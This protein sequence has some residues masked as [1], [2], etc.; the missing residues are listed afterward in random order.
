MSSVTINANND[1]S[2]GTVTSQNATFLT[3][4]NAASGNSASAPDQVSPRCGLSGGT[5]FILR[6]FMKFS[7]SSIPTGSK[8]NSVT[9][10]FD[11]GS[12]NVND[13]FSL[14]VVPSTASN[15][16]V[17]SDFS[18]VSFSSY[19]E[20]A[21]AS[22]SVGTYSAGNDMALNAT[23]IAAVQSAIGSTFAISLIM[24]GDLNA[25]APSNENNCGI[26]GANGANPPRIVVNY[27]PPGGAALF[28]II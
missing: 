16:L 10:Q 13:G 12:K 6:G 23:G 25:T 27:S 2:A 14:E 20:L 17:T 28:G 7:L 19:S 24:S 11:L 4:R 3:A 26:T 15:S 5:Y 1:N 8:I 21:F 18:K 9:L 22:M